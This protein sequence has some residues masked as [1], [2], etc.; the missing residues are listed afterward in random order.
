MQDP[1]VH[2][3]TTSLRTDYLEA[4]VRY[5][6]PRRYLCKAGSD[7]DGDGV[8]DAFESC[9]GE[10][11]AVADPDVDGVCVPFDI[12]HGND[13]TG[14]ADLDGICDDLDPCFG[15]NDTGDLD[16]DAVCNDVDDCLGD[17]ATLDSDDDGFCDGLEDTWTCNL[18]YYA[19][20][21]GCDCGCGLIDPDCADEALAFC[22]YCDN[23][24]SCSSDFPCPG[25]I[26][27]EDNA[28]CEG[29]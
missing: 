20:D 3:T 11:D 12:C 13:A 14:D 27:P 26:D 16:G 17:D 28:Q 25:L 21:D 22:D 23:D 1:D 24:G 8:C 4:S 19:S 9:P 15:D 5:R 2:P 29:E 6:L 18:D 10:D 7:A